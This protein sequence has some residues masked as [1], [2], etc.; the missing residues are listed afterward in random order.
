M[1]PRRTI[2]I[3]GAT[4]NIGQK[5]RKYFQD[6]GKYDLRLI[7]LNPERQ[8]GIM[9]A[10]L[11]RYDAE[12]TSLFEGVDAIIHLAYR[13]T[14]LV[15][16]NPVFCDN[17][18]MT[19]NVYHAAAEHGV[20][21]VVLASSV[22]AGYGYRFRK[23]LITPDMVPNPGISPYGVMKI[24]TEQIGK[25]FQERHGI[26]TIALRLGACLEGEKNPGPDMNG[27]SWGQSA[28]L[29]NS[30]LC[31][32]FEKAIL[33]E[34]IGFVIL[35]LTSHNEPMKWSLEE[36]EAAI[37]YRPAESHKVRLSP[38]RA[39]QSAIAHFLFRIVPGITFRLTRPYW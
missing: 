15:H 14:F 22:W 27:G 9:T 1:T 6:S 4:G 11:R 31:Q 33:A 20:R 39:A 13:P 26:S 5:L 24:A 21:R 32:G 34:G 7:C 25:S 18:G 12:W 16:W 30:D 10:D 29:G 2:A 19:L 8:P 35:N 36:T 37:G 38:I 17:V 23:L 28:W 3:T